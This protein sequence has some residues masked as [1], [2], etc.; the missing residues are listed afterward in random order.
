MRFNYHNE[1]CPQINA[2]KGRSY[3]VPFLTPDI[4]FE[5][6][7]S[8]EYIALSKWKFKYFEDFSDEVFD[9]IGVDDILVPSNWQMLGYSNP[10][11]TNHRYPFPYTPGKIFG[12]NSVGVYTTKVNL[13]KSRANYINFEGV[14]SA[15]YV[16][17]NS[18][19]VGYSK[20]NF[21]IT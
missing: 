3:Y 14:D 17:I 8:T 6:E 15:F 5:R 10:I 1:L 7:K 20:S 19:F 12:K 16:F 2:L 21:S 4:P 9:A 11:Y 18:K 13:D